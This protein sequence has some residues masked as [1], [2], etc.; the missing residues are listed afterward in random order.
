[1]T[2]STRP[3]EERCA[4][5]VTSAA[6]ALGATAIVWATISGGS[7]FGSG[8]ASSEVVAAALG[9]AG[10][11]RVSWL[12]EAR[13]VA[14]DCGVATAAPYA[15]DPDAARRLWALSEQ[16]TAESFPPPP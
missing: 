1:M 10:E 2:P 9:S 13:G 4:G 5:W 12:T 16:L 8:F 7:F 15:T 3:R 6:R 11:R 14:A